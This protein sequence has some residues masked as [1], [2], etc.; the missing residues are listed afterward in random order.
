[1]NTKPVGALFVAPV[2]SVTCCLIFPSRLR[3]RHSACRQLGTVPVV[4]SA[5]GN[6]EEFQSTKY[7]MV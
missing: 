1:M 6:L 7:V 2:Q 5:V 3:E 4:S